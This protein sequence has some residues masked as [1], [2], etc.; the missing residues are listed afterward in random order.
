MGNYNENFKAEPGTKSDFV[1]K[2]PPTPYITL[3]MLIM[4][5]PKAFSASCIFS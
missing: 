2:S 4:I 5:H 3:L 1:L